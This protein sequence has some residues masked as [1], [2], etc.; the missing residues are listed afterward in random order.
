MAYNFDL[1]QNRRNTGSVKWDVPQGALPM[2]L[3]DM[4]FQAAPEILEAFRRGW[5]TASSAMGWF[6]TPG[7]QPTSAG[8]ESEVIPW[9]P[10]PWKA[11]AKPWAA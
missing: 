3:A 4:D 2:S 10:C 7:M 1:V 5:I 8:E 9:G 11:C 6:R